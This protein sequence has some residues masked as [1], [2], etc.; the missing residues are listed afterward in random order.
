MSI[1]ATATG[2]PSS[3]RMT[4]REPLFTY[5]AL[6]ALVLTLQ[7]SPIVG[8]IGFRL[9]DAS[10]WSSMGI[11]RDALV[12][13]LATAV[14]LRSVLTLR[15][16]RWTR[17]LAWAAIT[18]ITL[19]ILALISTAEPVFVALNLRRMLMFPLLFFAVA[20]AQ[21]SPGQIFG[22]LRLILNTT[23]FVAV[24]GII[25]YFSPNALWRD[26][27]RVVEYFSSNPLDPFGALPFEESGRFFTW[28]LHGFF[29]GPVRRA[30]S[31]YLEPTTLAA[32]LMCG[33]C[34]A[35]A[36]RRLQQKN[37]TLK[38]LLILACGV[39]TLSKALGLFL[40]VM[41]LYVHFRIPSPRWIFTLTIIGGGVA[42][43]AQSVGLTVGKF[44]HLAGLATAI[45]HVASG[46]LFGEGIG[47]AGNYAALDTGTE[48][49][50]ESGLG[51][52]L[53]QIGL[54][55]L[56]YL[57]WIQSIAADVIRRAIERRDR[58]GV[59]FASMV[60]GWFISF[61]FS[62]SSLGIGGNALVFLALSLYLHRNYPVRSKGR[63]VQQ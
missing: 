42:L 55:A 61:L 7:F 27:L 24:F 46:H 10:G 41:V 5:G 8:L 49:G 38:L 53:A 57:F 43:W 29:G 14:L 40:L 63:A 19:A 18:L 47:N 54:A 13:L 1:E 39:L 4:R 25:E 28:D 21:L 52:L 2:L 32:A 36:A 23:V 20:A 33:I 62:A 16:V 58:T 37:A 22:L 3:A 11:A 44:E 31:T 50:M 45:N 51:N 59:F 35:A 30:V 12:L 17:S 15:L 34:L 56:I 26:H 48:I 6:V 9:T 60:L